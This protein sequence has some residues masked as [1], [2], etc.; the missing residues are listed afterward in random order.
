MASAK[1]FDGLTK[2]EERFSH[3][4]VMGF[5]AHRRKVLMSA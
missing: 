2:N 3:L 5:C 4:S 1:H